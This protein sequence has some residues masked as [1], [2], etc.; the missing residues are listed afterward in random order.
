M[1]IVSLCKNN[2]LNSR[3]D[4]R[5]PSAVLVSENDFFRPLPSFALWFLPFSRPGCAS[6]GDNSGWISSLHFHCCFMRNPRFVA[7]KILLAPVHSIA[8][9]RK[10]QTLS[11]TLNFKPICAYWYEDW[12]F[13]GKADVAYMKN[14]R[15]SDMI[16]Q[17]STNPLLNGGKNS[18]ALPLQTSTWTDRKL[19]DTHDYRMTL[20]KWG[21][22]IEF[23]RFFTIW[24]RP[25]TNFT[26]DK[27][28]LNFISIMSRNSFVREQYL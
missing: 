15:G 4:S 12:L 10:S 14:W 25:G 24:V 26:R 9:T 19:R 3:R 6:D 5:A 13:L 21:N 7:C 11:Y 16:L 17:L 1:M 22:Y 20:L 8:H 18:S 23:F 2:I 27:W 28:K